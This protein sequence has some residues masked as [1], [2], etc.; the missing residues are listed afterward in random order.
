MISKLRQRPRAVLAVGLVLILF[1]GMFVALH[2]ADQNARTVVVAYFENSNGVY[3]RDQVLIRGVA[4]GEIEK[5]EPEPQRAKITFWLDRKYKVPADVNAVIIAPILVA[6]RG[7]Q[8]T[9][10]YSGGPV[11]QNGAVI[12]R[13]RTAVPVEFD[14]LRG[15][16]ER[17]TKLLQ[18]T[19]PGG[20][21]T[22]GALVNTAAD[23][24]RGQGAPIRDTVIK[25]SQTVSALSDHSRDIFSTIDNL[26]MLVTG[27]HDSADLLE[28]LNRNLAAVS[29]LLADDPN[30][31]GRTVDDLNGVVTDLQSFVADNRE[32]LGT[33]SDK[34]AS[35]STALVGS[36]Y[37]IKQFLHISPTGLTDFM[38][39]YKA[40]TGGLTG[41]LSVN[42]FA[43]P[44]SFLCGAVESASRLGGTEAAK[45]CMQYMAPIIKNRQY[46]FPLLGINPFVAAQARPNEVT[47]SEDWMRP[48]F[49]PPAPAAGA[50]PPQAPDANAR[51]TG[52]VSTD[53]A[54]GLPGMLVPPG[55]GS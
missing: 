10:P 49:V 19:E 39:L 46:N 52:V 8:L 37:D 36:L 28:Q 47:Y 34:L 29:S 7:I 38:N 15:Q 12:P 13:D 11:L 31:V 32:A 6:S 41:I 18:P 43:N 16:L 30:K 23:N 4:V 55:H 20:V 33:T 1:A 26:S 45:L 2:T 35:I 50:P 25:L 17:L 14:D 53:P 22:L 3:P 54:A 48:D 51:T 27:F 40:S 42:N 9:P 5:I 24:L 21:N 44:V